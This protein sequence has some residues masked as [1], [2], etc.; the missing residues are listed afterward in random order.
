MGITK[1]QLERAIFI[2]KLKYY[3]I[4]KKYNI[5]RSTVDWYI[6]RYGIVTPLKSKAKPT[7]EEL[8]TL[9]FEKNMSKS[10][11]LKYFRMGNT[12]LEKLFKEYGLKFRPLGTNQSHHWTYEEVKKCF[13]DIGYEL[14]EE[15]YINGNTPMQYKCDKGHIGKI[16][17]GVI[18]R[19]GR[20]KKCAVEEQ[21]AKRRLTLEQAQKIF[22]E[23]G[24]KLLA[25]EYKNAVT[26]MK[27]I[28]PKCGG[29]SFISLSNFK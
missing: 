10:E 1:E 5:G 25:T 15:S 28:C 16:R 3:E 27:F 24:A 12:T 9:Y 7:K 17:F 14:L 23:R 19:G 26:P 29:K 11:L 6:N 21:A 2:E 22:E 8:Y 4:A 13:S 18:L 20:C